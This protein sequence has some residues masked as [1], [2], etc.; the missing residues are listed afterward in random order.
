VVATTTS[1]PGCPFCEIIAGRLPSSDLYRDDLVAAFLDIRPITTGH[2][3]VVPLSHASGLADLPEETGAAMFVAAQRMAAAL[4]GSE[5]Q[6]DGI[7]FFLADGA[8]AGQEVEHVH[9]HVVPRFA[10]DGFTLTASFLSPDRIDLDAT[11]ELVRRALVP[12]PS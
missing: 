11:A 9:L 3:L 6:C 2:L 12:Q 10:G 8:V 4:R 5:I 1:R 7:N